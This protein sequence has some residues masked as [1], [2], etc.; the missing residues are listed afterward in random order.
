[1][2]GQRSVSILLLPV[3]I[4]ALLDGFAQ[5]RRSAQKIFGLPKKDK[6]PQFLGALPGEARPV[7]ERASGVKPVEI[8]DYLADLFFDADEG[9]DRFLARTGASLC[10][11]YRNGV[12]WFHLHFATEAAQY[13]SVFKRN[14]GAK[15]HWAAHGDNAAADE[16]GGSSQDLE[17][18]ASDVDRGFGQGVVLVKVAELL[19][20][21]KRMTPTEIPSMVWLRPLDDC[22]LIRRKKSDEFSPSIAPVV[23]TFSSLTSLASF[24]E[25]DREL[26][27][28]GAIRETPGQFGNSD[29]E[30]RSKLHGNRANLDIPL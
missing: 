22:L 30:D 1:V 5:K 26:R 13:C 10:K 23:D 15:L 21:P 20:K 28:I 7:T 8:R 18:R 17:C 12:V 16:P 11:A 3:C 29:I 4:A 24:P 2:S 25:E 6:L 19:E 14:P 27:P 9:V